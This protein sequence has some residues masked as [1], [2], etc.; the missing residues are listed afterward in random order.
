[1]RP[2]QRRGNPPVP[3]R[4]IPHPFLAGQAEGLYHLALQ[5]VH[6]LCARMIHE[7]FTQNGGAV[8]GL[9]LLSQ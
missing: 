7:Q 3:D 4:F 6:A 8:P 2:L 5:I 1:M 9:R